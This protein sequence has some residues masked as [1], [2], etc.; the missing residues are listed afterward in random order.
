VRGGVLQ[1]P[2]HLDEMN[3]RRITNL[4]QREG[5]SIL[6]ENRDSIMRDIMLS[7]VI[8]RIRGRSGDLQGPI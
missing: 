1:S 3:L 8:G 5:D 2:F 4:L 6:G 7:D